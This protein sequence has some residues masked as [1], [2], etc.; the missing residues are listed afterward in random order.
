MI[1]LYNRSDRLGGNFISKLCQLIYSHYNNIQTLNENQY[2]KTDIDYVKLWDCKQ[3][4]LHSLFNKVFINY[5]EQHNRQAIKSLNNNFFNFNMEDK[6]NHINL[7]K[8]MID[9]IIEIKQDLF[10][11]FNKNIK[12]NFYNYLKCNL[13]NNTQ[14]PNKKYICYHIRLGDISN[15]PIIKKNENNIIFNYYSSKINNLDNNFEDKH[16]YFKNNYNVKR[17]KYHEFQ[18]P[19][20]E[21]EIINNLTKI[22]KIY[23]SHEVYLVTDSIDKISNNIKKLN[24]PIIRNRNQ[25]LDLWFL[26]HSDVLITSKSSFSLIAALLHK[27]SMLYLQPWG[28]IGS[29]GLKTKFDKTKNSINY[30]IL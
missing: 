12:K 5:C 7:S 28:L 24:Y 2:F 19:V 14:I 13:G 23:P 4:C 20:D 6:Y 30:E 15:K 21:T 11:Y 22:K 10:S 17:T 8:L 16:E 25:D 9:V 18:S 26:I 1:I 29:S 3:S 27:G